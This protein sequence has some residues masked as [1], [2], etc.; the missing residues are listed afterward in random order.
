MWPTN[1]LENPGFPIFATGHGRPYIESD[2]CGFHGLPD[3]YVRV[4][5]EEH[6]AAGARQAHCF[7]R[8]F[9]LFASGDKVV[10]EDA[11]PSLRVRLKFADVIGDVVQSMKGLD[12]NAFDAEVFTPDLLDEFRVVETLDDHARGARRSS[13]RSV[14]GN[15]PRTGS[16]RSVLRGSLRH[17]EF[18][19]FSLIKKSI[20]HRKFS[21]G[22]MS[23]FEADHAFTADG[24]QRDG[25]TNPSALDFFDDHAATYLKD[26]RLDRTMTDAA[27][28]DVLGTPSVSIHRCSSRLSYDVGLVAS[29]QYIAAARRELIVPRIFSVIGS[30]A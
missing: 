4:P 28:A 10:R 15:R 19:G 3:V 29:G 8:K 22:A 27:I 25:R 6:I 11:E 24:S 9:G 21:D 26:L 1:S 13:L 14:N 2:G 17:G 7:F 5:H 16:L 12:H 30:R 18:D 23:V 20:A